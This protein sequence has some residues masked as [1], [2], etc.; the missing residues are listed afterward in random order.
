MMKI[1]S[2]CHKSMRQ[3]VKM[4]KTN[5]PTSPESHKCLPYLLNVALMRP[6]PNI[7]PPI[8]SQNNP[9]NKNNWW[10]FIKREGYG[11]VGDGSKITSVANN[12][13]DREGARGGTFITLLHVLGAARIAR[14]TN[15]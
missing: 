6:I 5:P 7:R 11:W 13:V 10:Y 14:A 9:C 8:A 15:C 2:S 4:S 12:L 3:I 1:N